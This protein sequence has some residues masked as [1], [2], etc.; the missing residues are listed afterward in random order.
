MGNSRKYPYATTDGFHVL[1]PPPPLCLRKFQNVLPLPCPQNSI[2][3]NPPPPPPSTLRNFRF[4][5]KFIFDL[6][7]PISTNEHELMLPQGCDPVASGEKLW[8]MPDI[9]SQYSQF[10][11]Y[12]LVLFCEVYC[13]I[14]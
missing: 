13:V 6:A 14:V 5:G 12:C 9:P 1:T 10:I 3:V 2:I 11:H 7:T 4:F 8:V